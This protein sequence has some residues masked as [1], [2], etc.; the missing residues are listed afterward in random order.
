MQT[1]GMPT[2]NNSAEFIISAMSMQGMKFNTCAPSSD[3]MIYVACQVCL[4][5]H[6]NP[7]HQT[8]EQKDGWETKNINRIIKIYK[9]LVGRFAASQPLLWGYF[10]SV[11]KWSWFH[12]WLTP[13]ERNWIDTHLGD[14]GA[15]PLPLYWP[16]KFVKSVCLHKETN[17]KISRTNRET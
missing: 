15:V 7:S 12:M 9:G 3:V 5:G 14:C 1:A 4:L 6:G 13:V 10:P 17:N 2:L 16:Q 11:C 8:S